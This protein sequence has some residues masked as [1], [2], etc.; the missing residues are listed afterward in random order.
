METPP[1]PP[2]L[3]KE[4]IAFPVGEPAPVNWLKLAGWL[5]LVKIAYLTLSTVALCLW[6]NMDVG[7]FHGVMIRWPRSGEP[8]FAS[9]FA[10]W[11]A[12]HY[13]FLSQMGYSR[14]AQSCAFYPLWPLCIRWFSAFTWGNHI[15]SGMLLA[16]LF[17]LVGWI[18]FYATAARRFGRTVAA[19][20]LAFLIIFPGSLFY[21]YIYSEPLF[22]LLAMLLWYG[23]ERQ[24]YRMV[25]VAAF[26]LPLSRAVGLFCI[27]PLAWHL[28]AQK[29]LPGFAWLQR[30]ISNKPR[31]SAAIQEPPA[32]TVGNLRYYP[33]L[34]AP[35]MGWMLYFVLMTLWT[36][37]PLEGIQAQR[38]WGNVH[39]IGNLFDVPKF[40]IGLVSFRSLHEFQGSILDRLMFI[41]LVL[42]IPT[43]WRMG[44]DLMVWTYVLGVLP[45]MSGTFVSF[46]R[47]ESVVFPMFL[48]LGISCANPDRRW[49]RI[50][51]F[52]FCAFF[53]IILLWRF[54]NFNWA[55]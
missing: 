34:I 30:L 33:L 2:V 37:N 44:K 10:T 39:S 9:H 24:N 43:I 25:W 28:A 20:G 7:Q 19:L 26:F 40:L 21:Q 17:S 36:G 1:I 4:S 23:L 31:E 48:A 11:D 12:S 15:I 47:Y 46:T 32:S 54:L 8:V 55:G 51:L 27:L 38:F 5:A 14:G 53:H 52:S 42:E 6:P 49:R 22:F 16:N 13:L 3:T 35:L 41:W 29:P 18:V 45:A 50:R